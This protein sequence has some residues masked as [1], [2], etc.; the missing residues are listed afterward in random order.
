MK[1]PKNFH[2]F[3]EFYVFYL[4]EHQSF[5]C[6]RF[7]VIGTSLAI[8]CFLL[9][10]MTFQWYWLILMFISG[11]GFAWIGHLVFEK[12]KPATWNYPIYS[13][14]GDFVMLWQIINGQLKI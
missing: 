6:R 3:D 11:Y 4:S 2:H 1:S 7:H 13:L 9:F 14:M 8:L 12:N 5:L 10:V